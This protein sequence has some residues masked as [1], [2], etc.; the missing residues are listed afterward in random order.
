MIQR[1]N[2][3]IR[4]VYSAGATNRKILHIEDEHGTVFNDVPAG[5]TKL[6][7]IETNGTN[8]I[9][10]GLKVNNS[11]MFEFEAKWERLSLSES[12]GLFWYRTQA[13][14]KYPSVMSILN[15]NNNGDYFRF[16]NYANGDFNTNRVS[17][18]SGTNTVY[19]KTAG[20][21]CNLN[22]TYYTFVE[23]NY[24]YS[25]MP[26]FDFYFPARYLQGTDTN[27]T[28]YAVRIYF[29]NVYNKLTGQPLRLYIPAKQ[30]STGKVGMLDLMSGTFYDRQ[31]TGEFGYRESETGVVVNPT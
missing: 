3:N 29:F 21:R 19:Y 23:Q 1:N 13:S 17:N 10:T 12:S 4:H 14:N 9:D 11:N 18:T 31:G 28:F 30:D 15:K 24:N 5:Y 25:N 20:N 6:D 7:Y 22:G 2:K 16:A 8:Y 27:Y 26:N